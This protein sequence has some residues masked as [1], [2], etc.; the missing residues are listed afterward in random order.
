MKFGLIGQKLSHSF[1]KQYFT[2]KFS[3]LNLP[4]H[5][6]NL[7]FETFDKL[8]NHFPEILKNY[9]GLNVTIPYKEDIINLLDEISIEAKEIG[10]INTIVVRNNKSKGYNTD[11]LGFLKSIESYVVPEYKNALILGTGGASKAV[12]YTLETILKM[13]LTF[14]STSKFNALDYSELDKSTFLQHQIIVNTTPLG[15]YPESNHFPN[16]P[17]QNINEHHFCIDLIYNP[18]ET[19][20]LK[21]C[22]EQGAKT[23]N[24]YSM[25]LHQAELSYELWKNTHLE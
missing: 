21:K 18:T 16:I 5:Y 7:E 25:L 24:G 4:F 13:N 9:D 19:L 6:D 15:M 10:A 23:L 8:K 3:E 11:Y 20:F 12:A 22:R 14:V 1:S 17:Y 2:Q